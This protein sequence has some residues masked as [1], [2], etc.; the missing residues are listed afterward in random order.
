[1]MNTFEN[2]T[3][4]EEILNELNTLQND[5]ISKLRDSILEGSY[6]IY[7]EKIAEKILLNGIHILL[8]S[9]EFEATC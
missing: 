6:V 1:M 3:E 9:K 7:P 8:I 5:M 2:M 4:F